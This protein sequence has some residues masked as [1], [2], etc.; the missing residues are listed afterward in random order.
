MQPAALKQPGKPLPASQQKVPPPSENKPAAS[1]N[2]QYEPIPCF[3]MDPPP[4]APVAVANSSN[5]PQKAPE[6]KKAQVDTP[7][8][9]QYEPIPSIDKGRTPASASNSAAA[10]A[11]SN[12]APGC[13]SSETKKS[14]GA[15]GYVSVND[16]KTCQSSGPTPLTKTPSVTGNQKMTSPA[17]DKHEPLG[18]ARLVSLPS[19]SND[20]YEC[21]G[22][23]PMV[24]AP[25]PPVVSQPKL[26]PPAVPPKP[27][28]SGIASTKPTAVA[29][30]SQ[31]PYVS[32]PT[33]AA[34]PR[35][36]PYVSIPKAAAPP[37]QAP[38][39]SVPT[40]VAPP[41]QTPYASIPK[42][43]APP[44]QAPYVSIPTAV[45]PRPAP[46]VSIPKA[47]VPTSQAPYVSIPTAVAPPRQTPYASIPIASTQR[48]T[49]T[50]TPKTS[51]TG[52]SAK[53][54]V[55]P[56]AN[57]KLM[58]PVPEKPRLSPTLPG[59]TPTA[60][61]PGQE[62]PVPVSAPQK[63]PSHTPPKPTTLNGQTPPTTGP[64][65]TAQ[66]LLGNMKQEP[67]VTPVKAPPCTKPSQAK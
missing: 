55:N 19:S 60:L 59:A 54:P 44:R 28:V 24:S 7:K 51:Q 2:D 53:P 64:I 67:A 56:V 11:Q 4:A 32:I 5:P 30:T 31:A 48:S 35:Q 39:V 63:A 41:R 34:P 3:I 49:V 36:A 47:A 57:P 38:Y 27:V 33:A 25:P 1:A 21:L 18:P 17:D 10:G 62:K 50:S 14:E 42:A 40:A 22:N 58:G 13:P 20:E 9:D 37:R 23:L 45:P 43:A 46:Y 8:D 29:P 26:V 6:G 66:P 65:N 15:G 16:V 12:T 61:R 52:D